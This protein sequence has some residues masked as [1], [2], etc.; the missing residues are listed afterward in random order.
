MILCPVHNEDVPSCSLERHKGLW[1]CH[2]CGKGGDVYTLLHELEGLSFEQAQERLGSREERTHV[3]ATTMEVKHER[4]HPVQAGRM[5]HL[6]TLL[7]A[8]EANLASNHQAQAYI[9]SRGLT[10]ATARTFRLGLGTDAFGPARGRLVI[11]YLGPANRPLSIRT[12]CITCVGSCVGHGK[13]MGGSGDATR[14]FNTN[15]LLTNLTSGYVAVTEGE[16]DCMS[17]TQ[18]GILAVGFPGVNS[19]K[20]HHLTILKGFDTVYVCGDNDKAGHEFNDK[21]MQWLPN[22]RSV[23]IK[24]GDINDTLKAH[25]EQGVCDLFGKV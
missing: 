16:A 15:A 14:M 25:G 10:E 23:Y 22:A 5:E 8:A 24:D 20:P 18:A 19:V 4:V 3:T 2:S 1:N 13:Y 7:E 17:L 12:R 9:A 11:P 6:E 21:M